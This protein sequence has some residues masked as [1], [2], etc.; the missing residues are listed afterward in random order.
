MN[1]FYNYENYSFH[2]S[3]NNFRNGKIQKL[4]YPVAIILLLLSTLITKYLITL[5]NYFL[6]LNNFKSINQNLNFGL[7][8][9]LIILICTLLLINK[10]K[11]FIKR[12]FLLC[13]LLTS[14]TIW[15]SSIYQVKIDYSFLYNQFLFKNILIFENNFVFNVFLLY[16][17]EVIFYIWSYI[18]YSN[19]ISNWIVPMPVKSDFYQIIKITIFYLG[20]IFYYVRLG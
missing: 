19:N 6:Y 10:T 3:E 5:F 17:L 14:L 13:Y 20:V 8:L 7:F 18:S 11:V 15:I 2:H 1:S 4:I 9:T 12:T 16:S